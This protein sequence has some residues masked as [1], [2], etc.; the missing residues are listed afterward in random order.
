M[1]PSSS[2]RSGDGVGE[3][4]D[5]AQVYSTVH[6]SPVWLGG[7]G[8]GPV[9]VTTEARV[10][11]GWGRGKGG[12]RGGRRGREGEVGGRGKGRSFLEGWAPGLQ[13]APSTHPGPMSPHCPPSLL[14]GRLPLPSLGTFSEEPPRAR[15]VAR[16]CC[17]KLGHSHLSKA[18]PL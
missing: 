15:E 6:V 12:P 11:E 8:R 13:E 10:C 3:R 14:P 9:G 1:G 4:Q 7:W 18:P 16:T 5:R 2:G 17:Q